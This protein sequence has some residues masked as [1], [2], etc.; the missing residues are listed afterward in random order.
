MSHTMK[1]EPSLKGERKP[2]VNYCGDCGE[3][4]DG[5]LC[6]DC[7]Y[8]VQRL[9]GDPPT[10]KFSAWGRSYYPSGRAKGGTLYRTIAEVK[11]SLE[12]PEYVAATSILATED[13]V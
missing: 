6:D 9:P 5:L 2:R 10:V 13:D 11:R 8:E 7:I 3:E 12:N 4:C 1:Y